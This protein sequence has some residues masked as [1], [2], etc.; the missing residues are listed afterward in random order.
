[1]TDNDKKYQI[2]ILNWDKYQREMK[3]GEKRRRHREWIALSTRIYSDP[4]FLRLTIEQR[5]CWV[6]LVCYAGA[7][8]PVFKLSPSDARV[9]FKLRRSADFQVYKNQG[10]IE[11]RAATNKT[12]RTNKTVTRK[13][14]NATIKKPPKNIEWFDKFWEVWPK[15][16]DKI[17]AEE[18]WVRDNLDSIGEDIVKKLRAQMAAP[19]WPT[20]IQFVPGPAKWLRN[21]RWND[22]LEAAPVHKPRKPEVITDLQRRI[23]RQKADAELAALGAK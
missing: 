8:G 6:M 18:V 2:T 11:L 15:R 14:K 5:Y 21:E 20:D 9:L 19:S 22:E 10:F 16:L 3:G 12:N 17:K 13:R 1:V 4:D 23:D 7:V